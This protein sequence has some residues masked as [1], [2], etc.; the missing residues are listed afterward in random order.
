MIR[1]L[2][3]A[4]SGMINLLQSNDS[5]A[6]DLAN[7]N[8]PGFK[9]GV[10]IFKAFAPMLLNK[11]SADGNHRDVAG[12]Q[13]G[14]IHSGSGLSSIAIDFSQGQIKKVENMYDLALSGPGFFEI[15]TDNGV[16]AYTR[17][18]SFVRDQEGYLTTRNGHKV[19][20]IDNEPIKID[21]SIVNFKV[22][23]DGTILNDDKIKGEKEVLGQLK[24]VDFE[25]KHGLMRHGNNLFVDPGTANPI[26]AKNCTVVQGALEMSN[27]NVISTMTKSIEGMRTYETLSR[28]V[29]NTGKN[30]EK[31]TEQLGK[32]N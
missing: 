22:M 18:G 10:T 29:D 14:S 4:A 30:I 9:Q 25:N 5:I 23:A 16:T 24:L 20:G 7:I 32:Y 15:K 3:T 21:Q 11:L 26:A 19:I 1:G 27:A 12:G 2:Y 6:N 28:I 8:T 13:V 31:A 17:D